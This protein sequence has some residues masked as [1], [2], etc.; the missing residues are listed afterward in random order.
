M[1]E[2]QVK[3]LSLWDDLSIP[4]EPHKQVFGMILTVIGIEVNANSLTLT[5]PK[6][7]LDNLLEELRD[8]TSWLKKKRGAT[9]PLCC[10]QQLAGWLNWSFNVFPMLRPSLNSFYPKIAGKDQPLMKIWVNNAVRDDLIWAMSHLRTSLGVRLL[11]SVTWDVEDA[12]KTIFCDACQ[13]GLA[14][15]FPAHSQGYY[16]PVPLVTSSSISKH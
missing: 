16:S 4:H 1:P 8:F 5:L 9:W 6:E 10:W 15:W 11:S 12:D 2:N 7:S 14:F 3:L 13:T